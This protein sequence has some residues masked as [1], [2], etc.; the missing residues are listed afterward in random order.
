MQPFNLLKINTFYLDKFNIAIFNSY[1]LLLRLI[2]IMAY[3]CRTM[4]AGAGIP[5]GMSF[6]AKCPPFGQNT[7]ITDKAMIKWKSCVVPQEPPPST[8]IGLALS[9]PPRGSID[10]SLLE[11]PVSLFAPPMAACCESGMSDLHVSSSQYPYLMGTFMAFRV[12]Y[13][14]PW[15][16]NDIIVQCFV[17]FVYLPFR[18]VKRIV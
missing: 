14:Q 5:R 15:L 3:S 11:T 2:I 9:G 16:Y 7:F 18:H 12:Q 6:R 10:I 4:L 13:V 8:L 17:Y 1:L